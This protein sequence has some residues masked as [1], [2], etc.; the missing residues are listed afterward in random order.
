LVPQVTNGRCGGVEH[1]L[2]SNGV[3]VGAQRAPVLDGGVPVGALRGRAGALEVGEGGLVGGDHAR[4]A[5]RLDRHVADVIAALH[6]QRRMASPRYSRR[7]PGRRRCRSGAITAR[8][9]SLAV[10]PAGQLALDGDGHG[11]GPRRGRV[12]VASTCSTSL[13]PMPKASAPKAPWVEVC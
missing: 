3:V 1:D 5:R 2:A 13:V 4:R 12:C 9:T 7:S 6:R 10:T 8:I 11:P